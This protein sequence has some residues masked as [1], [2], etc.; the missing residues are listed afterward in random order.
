MYVSSLIGEVTCKVSLYLGIL[1][2]G[3]FLYSYMHDCTVSY[4]VTTVM[5]MCVCLGVCMILWES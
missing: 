2:E 5:F 4:D 1:Y 3:Q